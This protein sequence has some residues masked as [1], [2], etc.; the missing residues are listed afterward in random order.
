MIG[1]DDKYVLVFTVDEIHLNPSGGI[2]LKKVL[3]L[4]VVRKHIFIQDA[5][6]EVST[7]NWMVT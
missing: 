4:P 5:Q 3:S 7:G 1:Y 6:S 2:V